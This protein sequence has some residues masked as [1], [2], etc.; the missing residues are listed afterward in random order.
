[1][2]KLELSIQSELGN[3]SQVENFIEKLMEQFRLSPKVYA[4]IAL[5]LVEAVHI[6]SYTEINKTYKR[7]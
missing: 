2:N 5:S 1:M 3:I 7:K 6:L 4:N